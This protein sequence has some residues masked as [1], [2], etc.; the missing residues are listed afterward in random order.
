MLKIDFLVFYYME[1]VGVKW[2]GLK[3]TNF[4]LSD[5]LICILIFSW[6]GQWIR[7]DTDMN[8]TEEL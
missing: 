5:T 1:T 8:D 7:V 3:D 2:P 4:K 6:F